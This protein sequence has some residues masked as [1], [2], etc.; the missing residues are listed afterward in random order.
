MGVAE[1][2]SLFVIMITLAVIPSS[3]VLLVVT[4]SLA[5]GIPNGI[6][7]SIG[8]VLGDIIFIL[9]AI[10]GLSVIAETA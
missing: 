9:L 6:S 8:I 7:V 2:I 5:H 1:A 4:R 3:S 10:L